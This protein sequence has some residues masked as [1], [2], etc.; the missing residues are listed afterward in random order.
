MRRAASMRLMPGVAD[1]M[2]L[3]VGESSGDDIQH[4]WCQ[5]RIVF[6]SNREESGTLVA[7]IASSVTSLV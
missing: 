1:Q 4:S 5:Q 7:A 3:C 6:A 2:G